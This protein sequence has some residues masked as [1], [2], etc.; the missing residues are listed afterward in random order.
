MFG[1]HRWLSPNHGNFV[2]VPTYQRNDK[3]TFQLMDSL[4]LF[5]VGLGDE[6][7]P[8]SVGSFKLEYIN[9][10][11][12]PKE[13]DLTPCISSDYC[14]DIFK[15]QRP[16]TLLFPAINGQLIKEKLSTD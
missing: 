6:I 10:E 12:D 1:I 4:R 7:V 13:I 8:E 2:Y 15:Q 14:K 5:A 3:E 16:E 9:I 11:D